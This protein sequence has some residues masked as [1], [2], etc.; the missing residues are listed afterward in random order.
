MKKSQKSDTKWQS[1]SLI[2]AGWFDMRLFR[3]SKNLTFLEKSCVTSLTSTL[4]RL[5]SLKVFVFVYKCS[6][7]DRR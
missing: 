3:R 5:R 4:D 2:S 1:F 6:D 7:L